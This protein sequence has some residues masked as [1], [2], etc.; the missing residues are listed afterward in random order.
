[1][2]HLAVR[3]VPA[4][5]VISF[6]LA[7]CL[8]AWWPA[9]P[10]DVSVAGAD[11]RVVLALK[12]KRIG[13]ANQLEVEAKREAALARLEAKV[14]SCCHVFS[15]ANLRWSGGVEC[16]CRAGSIGRP[17]VCLPPSRQIDGLCVWVR[18]R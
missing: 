8:V 6:A 3:V 12:A 16:V 18:R 4:T 14:C 15:C 1:M 11:A 10:E 2:S 7:L 9:A 17:Q 13:R 5:F